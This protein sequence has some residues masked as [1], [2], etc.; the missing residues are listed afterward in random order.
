MGVAVR[1][2]GPA[3]KVGHAAAAA[4]AAPAAPSLR[5]RGQ[6]RRQPRRHRITFVF[7][8]SLQGLGGSGSAPAGPP[9]SLAGPPSLSRRLWRAIWRLAAGFSKPCAMQVSRRAFRRPA[10]VSWRLSPTRPAFHSNSAAL[11]TAHHAAG[12]HDPPPRRRGAPGGLPAPLHRNAGPGAPPELHCTRAGGGGREDGCPSRPRWR[13]RLRRRPPRLLGDG[14]QL[15][16]HEPGQCAS[17]AASLLAARCL[18]CRDARRRR[19]CP[20]PTLSFWILLV[21]CIGNG[22]SSSAPP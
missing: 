6:P 5:A 19:C 20:S 7:P 12:S 18:C 11:S 22:Q 13:W 1:C 3:A 8:G 4:A 21:P 9:R 17:S 2:H 10:L 16:P 14:P 15:V